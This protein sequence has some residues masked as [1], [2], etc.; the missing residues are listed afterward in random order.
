M[1]KIKNTFITVV[2]VIVVYFIFS[3]FIP[4]LRE[5]F[6]FLLNAEWLIVKNFFLE[7]AIKSVVLYI[8]IALIITGLGFGI[9]TK[10]EKKIWSIVALIIDVIG[11]IVL[12]GNMK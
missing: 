2:G 5:P 7:D 9:S 8:V 4:E 6:L 11:L 1:N 10:T 12:I 3:M